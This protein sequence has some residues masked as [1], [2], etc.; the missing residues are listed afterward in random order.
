VEVEQSV[1]FGNLEESLAEPAKHYV[2]FGAVVL[3]HE[4]RDASQ[5]DLEIDLLVSVVLQIV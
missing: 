1:P 2:L 4:S 3:L 5:V